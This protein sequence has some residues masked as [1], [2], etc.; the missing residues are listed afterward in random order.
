[1]R[2]AW[3]FGPGEPDFPRKILAAAD[4][5][6]ADHALRVVVNEIGSPTYA[7]DLAAGILELAARAP[8]GLYHVVNRGAVSRYAWAQRILARCRGDVGLVPIT[9][10]EFSRASTAPPWAVLDPRKA[11]GSGVYLR[12]WE[13]AFEAYAPALCP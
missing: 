13:E 12:G 6:P 2:T 10:A 11:E 9:S 3:L 7:V 5:L 4:A 1:M 8:A